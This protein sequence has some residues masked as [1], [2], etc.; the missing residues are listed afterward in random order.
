MSNLWYAGGQDV[1]CWSLEYSGPADNADI[2]GGK[3]SAHA[4]S[5][6]P[7][8]GGL[9]GRMSYSVITLV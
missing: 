4:V 6:G 8:R 5:S 9:R 3:L 7:V 2:L 1:L